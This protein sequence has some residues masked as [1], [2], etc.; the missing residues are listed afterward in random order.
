MK[1]FFELPLADQFQNLRLINAELLAAAKL[2]QAVIG[3]ADTSGA[4]QRAAH[5]ALL[6][7]IS[8]AESLAVNADHHS[9]TQE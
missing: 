3:G 8:N 9:T 4:G 1:S 7:A 6:V 2:A 5:S